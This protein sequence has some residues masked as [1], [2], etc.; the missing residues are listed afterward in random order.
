MK[1]TVLEALATS[2][3]RFADLTAQA[4]SGQL[5]SKS[6]LIAA[7]DGV[8]VADVNAVSALKSFSSLLPGTTTFNQ[9]SFIIS[10]NTGGE[11]SCFWKMV[12]WSC[13]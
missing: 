2:T 9:I 5:Q 4:I 11:K 6:E 7:I 10:S 12:N 8:T 3:G 13:R 1:V